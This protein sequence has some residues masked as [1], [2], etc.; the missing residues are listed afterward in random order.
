MRLLMCMHVQEVFVFQKRSIKKHVTFF[1]NGCKKNVSI[2]KC[3]EKNCLK[4]II[5]HKKF[6]ASPKNGN[7]PVKK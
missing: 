6:S 3:N 4:H 5:L 1:L 7:P 2:T